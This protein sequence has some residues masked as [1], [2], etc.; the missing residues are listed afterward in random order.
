M[1]KIIELLGFK[2][3]N[4]NFGLPLND[5]EKVV[6]VVWIQSLPKMPQYIHGV[7]NLHGEIIPVINVRYIFGF[8][9]KEIQLSDQLIIANMSTK[10]F[11]LLVDLTNEVIGI[12]ENDIVKSNEIIVGIRYLKG[13]VEL[14][15][16]MLLINNIEKFLSEDEL[17]KLEQALVNHTKKKKSV[18]KKTKTANVRTIVKNL[19]PE[20]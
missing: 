4:Q 15:D 18:Q 13:V 11:A 17:K 9:S 20:T 14:K 16:G 10:K 6:Q 5:V 19:K 12:S 7:I 3:D 2:L 8:P 1:G